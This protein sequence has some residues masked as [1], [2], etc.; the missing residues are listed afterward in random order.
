MKLPKPVNELARGGTWK[1][2]Y[3]L[4][5]DPRTPRGISLVQ[6]LTAEDRKALRAHARE[7][8]E[9][10]IERVFK[11]GRANFPSTLMH[12]H[13]LISPYV[14]HIAECPIDNL[15]KV[16]QMASETYVCLLQ[17]CG[18]RPVNGQERKKLFQLLSDALQGCEL[19]SEVL[20]N[21]DPNSCK[22]EKFSNNDDFFKKAFTE[23]EIYGKAF[24][25]EVDALL[26]A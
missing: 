20:R 24:A 19:A 13:L 5:P 4:F 14:A 7:A 11:Y 21:F 3:L 22:M 2:L 26:P 15:E 6:S 16:A 17:Y 9:L 10:I 8:G 23:V 12:A 18:F 1:P 25:F